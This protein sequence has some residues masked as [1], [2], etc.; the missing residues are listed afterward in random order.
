MLSR[1]GGRPLESL[2]PTFAIGRLLVTLPRPSAE[3]NFPEGRFQQR[4]RSDGTGVSLPV[5]SN[6]TLDLSLRYPQGQ[7]SLR[8]SGFRR[9]S[10]LFQQQFPKA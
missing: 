3:I 9:V 10:P 4:S 1:P 5:G 7:S 2:R 8:G 6:P